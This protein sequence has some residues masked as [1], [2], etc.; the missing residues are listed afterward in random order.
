M[1]HLSL[2]EKVD[3]A[4]NGEFQKKCKKSNAGRGGGE[5]NS[6]LVAFECLVEDDLP[7]DVRIRSFRNSR[8]S[9]G[10]VG[11]EN[12]PSRYRIVAH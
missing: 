2:V 8:V 10:S 4:S 5:G 12:L 6:S 7:S 3:R 9:S 1:S 11:N